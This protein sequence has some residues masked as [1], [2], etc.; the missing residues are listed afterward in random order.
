MKPL[1]RMEGFTL[2]EILVVI[3]VLLL[4][5]AILFPVFGRVREKG[6]ATTCLSNLKQIGLGFQQYTQDFDGHLP[7]SEAG[8]EVTAEGFNIIGIPEFALTRLMPYIKS[9][10]VFR[11]PDDTETIGAVMV[12]GPTSFAR[13]SYAPVGKE[14][15]PGNGSLARWGLFDG[16]RI[17][18]AGAQSGVSVA[19]I[20][21]PAET[22]SV[23]EYG[24]TAPNYVAL[25][26]VARGEATPTGGWSG[27]TL[28]L[29]APHNGGANYLF[30]DG[31]VKW[32]KRGD[33]N[34]EF[35]G[36]RTGAHATL[37]GVNYYYFW[38]SGVKNK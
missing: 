4:L 37:N 11:C 14:E 13:I 28:F 8:S 25:D 12:D 1:R 21:V 32:F 9:T 34:E 6:R 5:S 27:L 16:P 22:I 15:S 30:A 38:R 29:G 35:N 33:R 36:G 24:S 19:E 2:V 10:Q 23:A 20:P 26:H 17:G 7:T 18:K 31:H 3:G